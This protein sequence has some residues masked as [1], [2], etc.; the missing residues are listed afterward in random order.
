MAV[1]NPRTARLHDPALPAIADLL[2]EAVPVSVRV[3][4]GSQGI[5]VLRADAVQVMWWPGERITVRYAADLGGRVEGR[6]QVVATSGA[7]PVGAAIVESH[8][9]EVGVWT[10]PHD[11]AL[12]GLAP[13]TDGPT[14]RRLLCDLGASARAEPV[15]RLRAYRPGRRAVVEVSGGGA[16]TFLKL[17]SPKRVGALHQTHATLARHLPV[18]HSL[19]YDEELGLLAMEA[20][21]GVS[22]RRALETPAE[23]LPTPEVI[24]RLLDCLPA[25]AAMSPSR[26]AR[27][28]LARVAGLLIRLVPEEEDAIEALVSGIGQDSCARSVPVHGDLYEGQI[29]VVGGAIAGLVDVETFGMGRAGED[30]AAMIGHLSLWQQISTQPERTRRLGS[31]FLA[32]WDRRF[33]PTDLRRRAAAVILSLATG[34]FRV[35]SPAWP[36]ETRRRIRLA[37]SWLAGARRI[38]ERSLTSGSWPSHGPAAS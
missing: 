1:S 8:G 29:L 26:S 33:D 6:R 20:L 3:A 31:R 18:P 24:D 10:V 19:G 14:L 16:T 37:E 38:G 34:P 13:A 4:L 36:E 32:E 28:R 25:G 23:P 5:S 35:Q 15:A 12:P 9:T 21:P 30:Q 17:V 2:D 27:D 7:I 22:L 11:P